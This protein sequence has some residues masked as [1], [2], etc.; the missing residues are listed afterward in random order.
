METSEKGHK[1]QMKALIEG[2]EKDDPSDELTKLYKKD[3][4]HFKKWVSDEKACL[5]RLIICLGWKSN[6]K[7]SLFKCPKC[8][9]TTAWIRPKKEGK[10]DIQTHR[11]I[12]ECKKC[13][14]SPSPKSMTMMTGSR[15]PLGFWY[16]C[17]YVIGL[18]GGRVPWLYLNKE[19]IC[20]KSDGETHTIQRRD[21]VVILSKILTKCKNSHDRV[22]Y[23]QLLKLKFQDHVPLRNFLSWYKSMSW[24]PWRIAFEMDSY[25]P[26]NVMQ[27]CESR[28]SPN[29]IY[30]VFFC[31]DKKLFEGEWLLLIQID[32]NKNIGAIE[33]FYVSGIAEVADD[34]VRKNDNYTVVG[35]FLK[36]D[37]LEKCSHPF[38]LGKNIRNAI[39][40]S[41]SV[42][43]I[44]GLYFNKIYI[45]PPRIFAEFNQEFELLK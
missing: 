14:A 7:N 5:D 45:P 13:F 1:Q 17:I 43:R 36:D 8:K 20:F 25:S 3:L 30:R 38:G 40:K 15:K 22:A 39:R 37:K 19:R 6:G 26:M 18:M 10:G 35:V 9:N 33:W 28:Y 2:W 12:F 44:E 24:V 42:S 29:A 16:L 41:V 4:I 23:A 21:L 34:N 32:G 27:Y 31:D 11:L